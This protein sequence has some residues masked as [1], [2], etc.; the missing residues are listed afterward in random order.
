LQYRA[1]GINLKR[2]PLG[3]ADWL[4]HI[5][6]REKG[7]VRLIAKGGR[8]SRSKL[9]GRSELFVVNDL[10]VARGRSIDRIMQAESLHL[11]TG[12]TKDLTRLTCAQYLTEAVLAEASQGQ[13]H[14]EL[15]DLL[16]AQLGILETVPESE[17]C[18]HLV[19]SLFQVLH[20]AGIAPDVTHCVLTRQPIQEQSCGF[21]VEH[22][23]VVALRD[24]LNTSELYR[25]TPNMLKALQMLSSKPLAEY[26]LDHSVWK[27]VERFLRHYVEHHLERS[28]RSAQLLET[29]WPPAPVFPRRTFEKV[30]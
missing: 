13:P 3:E 25:L 15:F 5:L 21:S 12:L 30:T 7:V 27:Q 16:L 17:L 11:Y 24:S 1:V 10:H 23:G 22:G 19:H 14:A 8:K 18:A 20:A 6:T 9:G 28:L 4:L 26:K 29:L 2:Q